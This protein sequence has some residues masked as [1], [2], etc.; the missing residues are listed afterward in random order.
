MRITMT[1]STTIEARNPM[2]GADCDEQDDT[3]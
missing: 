2:N 1:T 3:R